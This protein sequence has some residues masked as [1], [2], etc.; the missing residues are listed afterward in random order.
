MFVCVLRNDVFVL[1]MMRLD[2]PLSIQHGGSIRSISWLKQEL[3]NKGLNLFGKM[4][5]IS[6]T[7]YC[8]V[9]KAFSI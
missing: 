1:L 2:K 5:Y 9:I 4:L 6:T 8:I 7:I 3:R